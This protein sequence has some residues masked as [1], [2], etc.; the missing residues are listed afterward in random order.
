M[1]VAILAAGIAASTLTRSNPVSGVV[2][3][4]AFAAL[5]GY[6]VFF[7]T[8]RY[9]ILMLDRRDRHRP[10]SGGATWPRPATC[11]GGMPAGVVRRS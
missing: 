11:V 4:M 10:R 5:A 2:A 1:C 8:A 3:G 9:L 6:I 7:H